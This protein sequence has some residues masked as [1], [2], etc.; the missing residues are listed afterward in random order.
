MKT[1]RS[2]QTQAI[3]AAGSYASRRAA[4]NHGK[5][6][7]IFPAEFYALRHSAKHARLGNDISS[8]ERRQWRNA[9]RRIVFE[10]MD[11]LRAT[12]HCLVESALECWLRELADL[13]ARVMQADTYKATGV[14]SHPLFLLIL[15]EVEI[16]VRIAED[17]PAYFAEQYLL[18]PSN[19][20]YGAPLLPDTGV[21]EG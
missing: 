17:S 14:Q 7:R 6:W 20:F 5:A 15:A 10:E 13:R 9:M 4:R 3:A 12:N 8:K 16:A 11:R 18:D 21:N 2:Y 19:P 1:L